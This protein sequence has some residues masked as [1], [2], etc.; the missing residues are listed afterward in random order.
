MVQHED[1]PLIENKVRT[2]WY[3]HPRFKEKNVAAYSIDD[4]A[5]AVI[6]VSLFALSQQPHLFYQYHNGENIIVDPRKISNNDNLSRELHSLLLFYPNYA[7]LF[8]IVIS[9]EYIYRDMAV[10]LDNICGTVPLDAGSYTFLDEGNEIRRVVSNY[11]LYGFADAEGKLIV[12]CCYGDATSFCDGVAGV[13]LNNIWFVINRRGIKISPRSYDRLQYPSSGLMPACVKGKWGY[14]SAGD[15]STVI[16]FIF[17][18]AYP[19]SEGTGLVSKN[20][21]MFYISADG[22]ILFE[23]KLF[24]YARPFDKGLAI[25]GELAEEGMMYYIIDRDGKKITKPSEHRILSVAG[26][27]IYYRKNENVEKRKLEL[28]NE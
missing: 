17:D 2:I 8:D 3:Q 25:V 6:A 23:N 15:C 26:G 12:G 11:G 18:Y 13:R 27:I 1:D 28:L 24:D 20:S 14:I 5:I 4:Y 19:Y 22:G 10:L 7:S 16:S 21:K 9:K